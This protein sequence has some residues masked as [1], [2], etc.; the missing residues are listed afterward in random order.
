M[1]DRVF[2]KVLVANRGEIACRVLQ[3]LQQLNITSVLVYHEA[4]KNSPALAMANEAVELIGDS[5]TGAYLD[6]V[7]II[8]ICQRL[9][10]DAVHPGYGFLSE[11][12]QFARSLASANITFI[13]PRA[14]IIELM[15]DKITSR[16]FVAEHGYPVSPSITMD[17]DDERFSIE[18][19][20]LGFP[21]VVKASAGGGGKGMSI[22]NSVQE[23]SG[24]LRV[25][26]SEA[27]KYFGDK[28]VYVE[29][30]F[31]SARHIEVQVLGDGEHVIHLAERDCSVQ[32]R[33]QKVIEESPAAHFSDAMREKI[34]K[35]AVGIATA[36]KYS[37]AGTVEFL[38][39]PEGELFFLEMNT[40]IQVEHPVTE[41]VTGVDLVVEQIKIAA[42]QPLLIKQSDIKPSGHAIECRICAEDSFNGFLPEIG[43]V[44]FFKIP[45]GEGVRFD[46]G[47]YTGQLVTSAYDPMLAKVVV[48]AAT[49]ELALEKAKKALA[50]LIILGV[51]TNIDYVKEILSHPE[52]VRGGVDTSFIKNYQH[53]IVQ[54]PLSKQQ[55]QVILAAALLKDRK[56]SLLRDATPSLYGAI[57]HWRN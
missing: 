23:L 27:E 51:K 52:F 5:P 55:Q 8:Q 1:N 39:T 50:E 25:A 33:F 34:C 11:N 35:V 18:A 31:S 36:A 13:G 32:R 43:R 7:Q 20:K 41:M 40:R 22:V 45:E 30:Y 6:M 38:Y 3:A 56:F 14:E 21:L 24:T 49:R 19:S 54:Q 12:S 48:H 4:D 17:A 28:R 37:S 53:S 46:G 15:G 9:G 47:I 10:V 16:N 2:N 26:A 29:R 44:L 42:G 57:G